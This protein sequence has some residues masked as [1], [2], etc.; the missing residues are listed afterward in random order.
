MS[1]EG[2][3]ACDKCRQLCSNHYMMFTALGITDTK[4]HRAGKEPFFLCVW[5]WVWVCYRR[6]MYKP[7]VN[8]GFRSYCFD[9]LSQC[10]PL[11][12]RSPRLTACLQTTLPLHAHHTVTEVAA[13]MRG[14]LFPF[15]LGWDLGPPVYISSTFPCELFAS[16]V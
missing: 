2:T 15:I 16:S 13:P 8:L 12:W 11:A 1:E 4:R 3:R 9:F 14:F 5:V 10:L 7:E 6:Y